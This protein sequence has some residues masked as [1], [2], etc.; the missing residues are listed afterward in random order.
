MSLPVPALDITLALSKPA[1]LRW[2]TYGDVS[3]TTFDS[4]LIDGG[5]FTIDVVPGP[6]T[7]TLFAFTAVAVL[8]RSRHAAGAVA[9]G[10]PKADG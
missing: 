10:P 4:Y 7:L 3:I 9:Y 5:M 6:T 8:R 2:N 1:G